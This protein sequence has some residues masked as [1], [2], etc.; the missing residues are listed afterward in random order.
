M[1]EAAKVED[2]KN[3]KVGVVMLKN[4]GCNVATEKCGFEPETAERLVKAGVAKY[5]KK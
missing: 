4:Y 1:A 5:D 2:V 3:T